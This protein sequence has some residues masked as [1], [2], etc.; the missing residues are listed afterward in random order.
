MTTLRLKD[1]RFLLSVMQLPIFNL[2]DQRLLPQINLPNPQNILFLTKK[3][4]HNS[5]RLVIGGFLYEKFRKSQVE[6]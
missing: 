1:E 2:G 4:N 6:V 3:K 5:D